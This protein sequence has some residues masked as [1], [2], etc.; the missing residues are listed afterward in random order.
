MNRRKGDKERIQFFPFSLLSLLSILL[1]SR[2]YYL[3]NT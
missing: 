2:D 3:L 1:D